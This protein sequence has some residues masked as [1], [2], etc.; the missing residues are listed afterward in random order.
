ME[1]TL[2][3]KNVPFPVKYSPELLQA[4]PFDKRS[5]RVAVRLLFEEFTSLCPITGQP[6][7]GKIEIHYKPNGKIVETKSL[8]LYLGSYR[9]EGIFQEKIVDQIAMDLMKVL[10]TV[11]VEVR[12]LFN[13]RGGVWIE[14]TAGGIMEDVEKEK[15]A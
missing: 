8:K 15:D 12:A 4:V 7:F 2:L 5:C 1:E 13:S 3:G 10:D 9:N 11:Q 6:D 14:P